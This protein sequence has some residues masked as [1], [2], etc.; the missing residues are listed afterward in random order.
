[1]ASL[2]QTTT[3]D[4]KRTSTYHAFLEGEVEQRPNLEIITHALVTR[5][6]L[7]AEGDALTARGVEYRTADGELAVATAER[8]VVLSR[9]VHRLTAGPAPVGGRAA[10]PSWRR[11]ASS[12][13]S[14]HPTSASTSRTTSRSACSSPPPGPGCP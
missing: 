14:T 3:R 12:A 13:T 10:P 1:M 5:I 11:W 2:L 9:R 8:E 4:G 7:E 6:V